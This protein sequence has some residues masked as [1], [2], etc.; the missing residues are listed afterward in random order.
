M[1][2]IIFL[3]TLGLIASEFLYGQEIMEVEGAIIVEE[4][5]EPIPQAGTIQWSGSDLEGWNGHRWVSLTNFATTGTVTDIDGNTYQ[6]TRIGNQEWMTENLKT[7]TYNDN[8]NI[9]EVIDNAA[10]A[11]LTT[12]ARCWHYNNSSSGELL[13]NWYAVDT[14]ILCPTDWHV[15]SDLDWT[16]LIDY[17]GGADIAGGKMKEIG[18]NNW[19]SPNIGASN[20]S[21]F[22][23][24]PTVTRNTPGTFS[25]YNSYFGKWWSSTENNSISSWDRSTQ[26]YDIIASRNSPGKRAG[27]S[28]RCIRD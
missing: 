15:P 20:E 21:G 26:H 25:L 18:T 3:I 12:G 11:G 14:G 13:Y 16:V 24:I 2:K 7:T 8:S 22:S 28:I 17:L 1:K 9:P 19:N 10:W 27:F 5:E 4:S 6:T 23:A